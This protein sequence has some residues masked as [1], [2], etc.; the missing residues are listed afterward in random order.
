MKYAM[1]TQ[2]NRYNIRAAH[3]GKAGWST[4]E[5]ITAILYS[6]WLYFLW[7]GI[8]QQYV[9]LVNTVNF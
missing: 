4:V 8:M 1:H 7:H 3:D 9:F 5:Y 2:H 6:N